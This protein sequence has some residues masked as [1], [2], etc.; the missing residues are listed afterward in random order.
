MFVKQIN[1]WQIDLL[2]AHDVYRITYFLNP[3]QANDIHV[4]MTLPQ[5]EVT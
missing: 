1:H 5:I 4:P 3:I 2:W